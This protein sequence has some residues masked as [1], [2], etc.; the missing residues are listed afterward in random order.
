MSHWTAG[1]LLEI[2]AET[3][4][5]PLRFNCTE[6]TSKQANDHF[7]FHAMAKAEALELLYRSSWIL[8]IHSIQPLVCYKTLLLMYKVVV[9]IAELTFIYLLLGLVFEFS[10]LFPLWMTV[11]RLASNQETTA[12]PAEQKPPVRSVK[13]SRVMNPGKLSVLR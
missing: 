10:F 9:K 7:L 8:W 11:W 5:Q 1:G 3:F 12:G 6:R 2:K 4:E 13:L